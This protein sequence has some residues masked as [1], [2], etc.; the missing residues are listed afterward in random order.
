VKFDYSALSIPELMEELDIIAELIESKREGLKNDLAEKFRLECE[1]NGIDFAEIVGSSSKSAGKKTG[2]K[3]EPKY[4]HP[5]S[6]K[7]WS[8]RGRQ[9]KWVVEALGS[10]LS[11][12][13]MT[14]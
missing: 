4:R 3:V 10:G 14:I 7:T 9:P 1:E 8:G 12:E 11:L 2:R 6:G 13:S 5:E